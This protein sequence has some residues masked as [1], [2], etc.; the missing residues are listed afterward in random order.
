[1]LKKGEHIEGTP[2]ELQSLL[3]QNAEANEFFESLS[4]SYKQG[5]CDWVGSAKQ[6]DTRK[7]RADK[8]L[9]MLLNKQKTL[10][11]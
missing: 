2:A 9:I 7:I 4:K 3:D 1:M 5:Y 8:A 10:K 11:T 6:E